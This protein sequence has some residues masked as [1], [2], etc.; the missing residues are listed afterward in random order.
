MSSASDS[1]SRRPGFVVLTQVEAGSRLWV[2]LCGSGLLAAGLV[3]VMSLVTEAVVGSVAP[4]RAGSASALMETCSEFGGALGI[5]VLGSIGTAAYRSDL[6]GQLPAGLAASAADAAREGLPAATAV[7]SS[8]PAPLQDLVLTAARHS[9]SHSMNV[10]ALVGAIMLTA[11]A[12]AVVFVLRGTQQR[13]SD[14]ASDGETVRP[15]DQE[16]VRP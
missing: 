11:T 16:P 10:V 1:W 15:A 3:M 9:F 5:A 2:V 12:V 14:P 4:E 6:D 8:L 13:I 7:A